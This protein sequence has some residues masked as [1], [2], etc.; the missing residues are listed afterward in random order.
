MCVSR[1]SGGISVRIRS[2]RV[3]SEVV[4]RTPRAV[5]LGLEGT[6]G[7]G[8]QQEALPVRIRERRPALV[9]SH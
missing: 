9:S 6:Q 8:S 4:Q 3:S 2:G 7:P 1:P 5:A